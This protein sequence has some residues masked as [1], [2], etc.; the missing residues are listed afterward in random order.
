MAKVKY[1]TWVRANLDTCTDWEKN[2]F[3]A[4]LWRRSWESGDRVDEKLDMSHQCALTAREGQWYPDLYQKEVANREREVI[5]LP[6]LCY[7]KAP[8]GVL[9]LG[10][11]PPAQER[12]EA[13]GT[14]TEKDHKDNQRAGA[15]LL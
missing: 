3:R 2:S 4:A 6:L 10:L 11:G 8:S 9:Y 7:C 5:I 12:N 13:F 15:P 1:C 14:G